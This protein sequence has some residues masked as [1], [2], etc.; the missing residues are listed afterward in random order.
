MTEPEV[1]LVERYIGKNKELLIANGKTYS[2]VVIPE[3]SDSYACD[4]CAFANMS[5][6][7]VACCDSVTGWRD[8]HHHPL[9]DIYWELQDGNSKTED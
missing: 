8:E 7:T 9:G 5:C 3:G 1:V 4:R 6:S 2:A